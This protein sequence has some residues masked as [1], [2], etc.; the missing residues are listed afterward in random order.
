VLFFD[1]LDVAVGEFI[2]VCFC[3][4]V[5]TSPP[6]DLLWFHLAHSTLKASAGVDPWLPWSR[7]ATDVV[8]A[9]LCS[10]VFVQVASGDADSGAAFSGDGAAPSNPGAT[11]KR[12]FGGVSMGAALLPAS[13][14]SKPSERMFVRIF[15]PVVDEALAE[16]ALIVYG[17]EYA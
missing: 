3:C 5:V 17:A 1:V 11:K 8:D 12:G 10:V 15:D 14:R 9:Y 4:Y 6:V 2:F 7:S 13:K 16:Y